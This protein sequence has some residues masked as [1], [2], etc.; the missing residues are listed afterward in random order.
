MRHGWEGD[1][2][3]EECGKCI[4]CLYSVRDLKCG[5]LLCLNSSCG[6][7]NETVPERFFC[8]FWES[9]WEV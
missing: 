8:T 2:M 5:L 4:D 6:M 3:Q 1:N 9:E 7:Y